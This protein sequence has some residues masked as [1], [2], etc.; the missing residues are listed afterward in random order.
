MF[1]EASQNS[2]LDLINVIK[3]DTSPTITLLL[4]DLVDELEKQDYLN[5]V[6]LSN[7]CLFP[8]QLSLINRLFS[9]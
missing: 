6:F 3:E 1:G 4:K 9:S 2:I 5:Q 8:L 7:S